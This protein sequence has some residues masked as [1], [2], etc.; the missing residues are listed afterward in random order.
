MTDVVLSFRDVTK[1]YRSNLPW[2]EGKLALDNV[3]FTIHAG[4]SIGFVGHNGAGKSTAI[5]IA[6][7]LRGQTGGEVLLQ[8]ETTKE[9]KSR[10]GV[11]YV[12]ERPLLYES[13]TPLEH[14]IAARST[15]SP[16]ES[17][18]TK[19]KSLELLDR[20]GLSTVAHQ[21]VGKFS[22]GMQQRV[23]LAYALSFKPRILILD[24]PM[25][26]LDPQGR[27]MVMDILQ[28]YR[29][30]G[31]TLVFSS[32]VI[33]DVIRL[34]DAFL[35]F[36]NGQVS[37]VRSVDNMLSTDDWTYEVIFRGF[38]DFETA[39]SIG[40]GTWRLRVPTQDI[41]STTQRLSEGGAVI[42]QINSTPNFL[43]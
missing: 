20:F 39:E 31:G 24:E 35:F 42:L 4:S 6:L 7:G 36:Q 18:I 40:S 15:H 28:D 38:S 5:S 9:P 29:A 12:P 13:L 22:K 41:A 25:S 33:A 32:H 30:A 27:A 2:D 37:P 26:G 16:S 43:S 10:E 21:Q 11:A 17:K 8:G 14:L 1:R 3:S 19:A 34:A 23:A